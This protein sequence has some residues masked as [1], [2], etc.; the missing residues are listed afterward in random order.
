L[1][2]PPYHCQRQRR[3]DGEH[4]EQQETGSE[5]PQNVSHHAAI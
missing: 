3:D 4:D 2:Q 5:T 1:D